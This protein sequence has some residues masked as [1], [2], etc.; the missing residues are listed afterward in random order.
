MSTALS[1]FQYRHSRFQPDDSKASFGGKPVNSNYQIS[2]ARDPR[3]HGDDVKCFV[4][5]RGG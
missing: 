5:R 2:T 4:L 3:L 1:I